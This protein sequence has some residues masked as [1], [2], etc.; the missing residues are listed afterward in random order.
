MPIYSCIVVDDDYGSR[1]SLTSLLKDQD[2]LSVAGVFSDALDAADF[3]DRHAVAVL[4]L[5]IDMPGMNGFELRRRFEQVPV[6]IFVS[7]HPEY[8]LESFGL[9]TLDFLSKP[10]A[11]NRFAQTIERIMSYM[12]LREK[13]G[14]LNQGTDNSSI[15]ITENYRKI[16][17]SVHDILYIEALKNYT[18]ILTGSSDHCVRKSFGEFLSDPRFSG[19]IQIHRSYAVQPRW[20]GSSDKYNVAMKGGKILPIGRSFQK[21]ATF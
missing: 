5:D 20:V 17:V 13:A 9:Q 12:E 6:C 8:A 21:Q 3:L 2:G 19:F 4:F 1:L 14:Y 11:E 10:V 16:E 18:R 15:S 7:A